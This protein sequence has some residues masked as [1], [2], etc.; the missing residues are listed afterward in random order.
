[1][2]GYLLEAQATVLLT[3]LLSVQKLF[4]KWSCV[5]QWLVRV[6]DQIILQYNS[7]D[8]MTEAFMDIYT[9]CMVDAVSR[10]ELKSQN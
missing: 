4:Q 1:M 7:I 5:K 2:M 8:D 9:E 6:L 10:I 3:Y